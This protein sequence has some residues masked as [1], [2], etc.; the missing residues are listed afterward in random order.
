MRAGQLTKNLTIACMLADEGTCLMSAY[1]F[2]VRA[3]I[4]MKIC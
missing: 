4:E 2:G 3:Q 1:C